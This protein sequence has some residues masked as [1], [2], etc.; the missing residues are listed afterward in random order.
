MEKIGNYWVDEHGNKMVN[1]SL[2]GGPSGKGFKMKF[3]RLLILIVR[4]L[5][6]ADI[7]NLARTQF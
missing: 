4:A 2:D 5:A 1:S 3:K 6:S 7:E